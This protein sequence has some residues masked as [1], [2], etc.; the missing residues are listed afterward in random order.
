MKAEAIK[1]TLSYLREQG[2]GAIDFGMILGSGL[3]DLAQEVQEPLVL[4][5]AAI[6]HFPISTVAGH[7]GKLVYGTLENKKVLMLQGRF[8]YYEGNSMQKITYPVRVLKALGAQLLIVTNAA[9]GVNESYRPGELMLIKDHINFMGDH[10]LIGPNDDTL[11]PRFPDMSHAYD[12][13]YRK[14]AKQVAA[15]MNLRLHEGVYMAFSGPSYETPAEIRMARIFGADAVGMSTVPEVL[16]ANHM[17]MS[18]LGI[19]CITNMAAGMQ[20]DLNHEEVVATTNR[21][22]EQ[23]QEF[24]KVILHTL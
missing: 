17:G 9:G 2:M 3:G 21:V 14:V 10:P 15:A 8:H 12:E 24:I 4:D 5:Y 1:E 13:A 19:S 18:V 23:F 7:A 22:K 16:V 20:T 11:G 6:P